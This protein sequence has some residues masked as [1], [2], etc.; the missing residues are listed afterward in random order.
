M[1]KVKFKVFLEVNHIKKTDLPRPLVEKI[2]YFW[3]LHELLDSIRDEDR[4]EL[5]EQLE[6]LDYGILGDIEEEYEDQL[7]NNDRLEELIKS[8]LVK[9]SIKKKARAKIRTDLTIIEELVAMKRTKN[10]TKH[11]L[12]QMGL[13]AKLGRSIKIGKYVIQRKTLWLY[14]Y[15]DIIVPD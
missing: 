5:L 3:K 6:Q 13:K 7:E 1:K 9:P 15:Y 4:H 11:E 12:Q 8:P 10:L 2:G 14:Y